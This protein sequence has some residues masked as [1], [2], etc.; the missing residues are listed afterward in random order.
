MTDLARTQEESKSREEARSL[1][2]ETVRNAR[3]W[4]ARD[5]GNA[6]AER[7]LVNALSTSGNIL[8][9]S[10]Q[11][12]QARTDLQEAATR[13]DQLLNGSPQ[14]DEFE[15]SCA[16]AH[17]WLSGT[18]GL[19]GQDEAA[20]AE[21][22]R[23]KQILDRMLARQP[24]NI[25]WRGQRAQMATATATIYRRLS[26]KDPSLK[27]KVVEAAL[28][29][30]TL[31]SA[32]SRDNPDDKT[33]LDNAFVMTTRYANQ[34]FR[35]PARQKEA[36]PLYL[37]AADTADRLVKS[38]PTNR[39][40]LYL[41]MN[42]RLLVGG[43]YQNLGDWKKGLTY[44]MEAERLV[45]EVLG[46]APTDLVNQDSKATVFYNETLA[47]KHLGR[48]DEA[49]ERCR[50]GLE[51]AARILAKNKDAKNPVFELDGLREQAKILGV[52]DL[53]RPSH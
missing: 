24:E 45:D 34:L 23:A 8:A 50:K 51:L 52:P 49:R 37:E 41:R 53:T 17:H 39:R 11:V 46:M 35:D 29:A 1:V 27:P 32:N 28:E 26:A 42:S 12:K 40:N 47:L 3:S 19:L 30:Y 21:L 44:T 36:V 13:C 18:F 16:R 25:T 20:A 14:H 9:D 33:T 38:D 7:A 15:F 10:G 5:P 31:A 6:A 22:E 4:A 2:D 48:L 43:M